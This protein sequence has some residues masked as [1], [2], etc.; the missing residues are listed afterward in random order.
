MNYSLL[1][2]IGHPGVDFAVASVL[3]IVTVT[4]TTQGHITL[5][6]AVSGAP[7]LATHMV[8]VRALLWVGLRY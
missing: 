5:A 2:L 7:A 4:K 3:S 1:A 8:T 6:A